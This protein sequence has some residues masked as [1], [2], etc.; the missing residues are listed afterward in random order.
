[1]LSVEAGLVCILEYSAIVINLRFSLFFLSSGVSIAIK[2]VYPNAKVFGVEPDTANDAQLSLWN[3]RLVPN[4]SYSS[5][6]CDGLRVSI[7]D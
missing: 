5:T 1:M 6:I 2:H 4:E 3:N 7:R